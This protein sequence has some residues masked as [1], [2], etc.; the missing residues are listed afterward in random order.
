MPKLLCLSYSA[1]YFLTFH[2][3]VYTVW[4]VINDRPHS[5]NNRISSYSNSFRGNNLFEF[6]NPKVTVHKCAEYFQGWGNT[7]SE[8]LCE[9]GKKKCGKYKKNKKRKKKRCKRGKEKIKVNT[10]SASLFLLYFSLISPL[11]LLYF[12]FISPLFLL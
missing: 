7:V 11:F 6:G 4:F 12:S 10:W 1:L 5:I 2:G 3:I 8:F 9:R